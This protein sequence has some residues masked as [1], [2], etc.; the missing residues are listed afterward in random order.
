[1]ALNRDFVG[2]RFPAPESFEVG[3]EHI[4]SFAVAIGDE[5][6]LYLST[7]AAQAAGYPDVIAPPT[8]LTTLGFRF[9][10]SGPVKDPELNLDYS[11]VVHG[12]QRFRHVR[13]V[14]AGD[15]LRGT[16]VVAQIKA[17][18]PH[19]YLTLDVEIVDDSDAPVCT[20]T[21]VVVSR[22]SAPQKES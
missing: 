17:M 16:T 10:D 18:G 7:E 5:N 15:R 13:P 11:M 19:E 4:R 22:G 20:M 6:P 14:V 1:M 3:R 2:R 8:F 12:E 9:A 21:Q